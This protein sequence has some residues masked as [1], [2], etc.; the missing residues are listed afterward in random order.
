VKFL[1]KLAKYS[2]EE[3][4]DMSTSDVTN[5]LDYAIDDMSRQDPDF[6]LNPKLKHVIAGYLEKYTNDLK[7][8]TYTSPTTTSKTSLNDRKNI[9]NSLL[10]VSITKP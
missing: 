1:N 8:S 4:M 6:K 5:L 10:K 3:L 2:D 7:M 9:F